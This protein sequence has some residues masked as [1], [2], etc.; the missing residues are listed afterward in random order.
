MELGRMNV[1]MTV[2]SKVLTKD[3]EGFAAETLAEVLTTR[4]YREGRHG[5]EAW[6][7]RASFTDATDLFIFRKPAIEIKTDMV[8]VCGGGKFEIVSIENVKG[9]GMYLSVLAREVKQSG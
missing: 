3:G 2:S 7:N 6:R 8:I 4:G 1:P 5:N 9:R